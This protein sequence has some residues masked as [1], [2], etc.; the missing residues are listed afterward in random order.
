MKDFR[1]VIHPP[2]S[3]WKINHHS[4]V[5]LMGSC[6]TENMYQKLNYFKINTLI[7][8]FGIVY[9]PSSIAVQLSHIINQHVFQEEDLSFHNNRWFSFL[10]HSDFSDFDKKNCLKQMNDSINQS[11]S[12]IKNCDV[13]FITYGTSWVYNHIETK[14]IVANCHKLPSKYFI[15]RILSIVDVINNTENIIQTIRKLNTKT[16]I[17]ITISPIR[18][19][20]DG[21]HENIL[22]KSTLFLGIQDFVNQRLLNYFPSYEIMMDDLRDYRF[23]ADDML[24]LSTLAKDYIW[25][26]FTDTYFDDKTIG[27]CKEFEKITMAINHKPFNSKSED[28]IQFC[29]NNLEEISKL[30]SKYYY[31]NLSK[32]KQYFLDKITMV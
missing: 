27:I 30:E 7:N 28:Y 4:N 23:Y 17:V 19:W 24:H 12:F 26:K 14:K 1:T 2:K 21:F 29:K 25:E 31:V 9:N 5:F 8:P 10:H 16:K 15:K 18:H 32:E 13:I 22:S 11:H 20:H 6:F 3:D